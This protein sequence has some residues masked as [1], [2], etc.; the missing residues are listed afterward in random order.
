M[1]ERILKAL[2]AHAHGHIEKHKINVENY[3]NSSV[4]VGEHSDII[5]SIEKEL[6]IIDKYEGH[7]EIIN[8]YFKDKPIFKHQL[9][10]DNLYED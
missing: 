10:K 8:R 2:E 1:R 7:L 3:L 4:G 6:E 9:N 5:E